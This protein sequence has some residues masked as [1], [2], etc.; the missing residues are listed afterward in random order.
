MKKITV[1]FE[2]DEKDLGEQWMN[3]DNLKLMLYSDKWS[4]KEELFKI[5]SYR[6]NRKIDKKQVAK[7]IVGRICDIVEK[8]TKGDI[9]HHNYECMENWI[10]EALKAS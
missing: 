2:F 1:E 10:E 4:T 7:E 5:S 6:E 8:N 9:G 3:I